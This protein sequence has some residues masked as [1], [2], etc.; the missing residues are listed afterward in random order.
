M[1]HPYH[2]PPPKL[3][4]HHGQ[5]GREIIRAGGL[6]EHQSETVSWTTEPLN[7]LHLWMPVQNWHRIKLAALQHER[8]S[9]LDDE[10]LTV[11]LNAP[12]YLKETPAKASLGLSL[13]P[14]CQASVSHRQIG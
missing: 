2:T 14:G 13:E 11:R 4:G 10:L 6:G 8:V 5:E 12:I 3:R 1:E 7:A 9:A